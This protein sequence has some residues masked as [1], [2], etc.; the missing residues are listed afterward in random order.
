MCVL[1]V[2]YLM[3]EGMAL[4]KGTFTKEMINVTKKPNEGILTWM[5]EFRVHPRM[6]PPST[7]NLHATFP[8]IPFFG[9]FPAVY[10]SKNMYHLSFLCWNSEYTFFSMLVVSPANWH[11]HSLLLSLLLRSQTP[12]KTQTDKNQQKWAKIAHFRHS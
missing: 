4:P 5:I 12:K 8:E 1:N 2:E 7:L 3:D 9:R 11:Y 10:S 6:L